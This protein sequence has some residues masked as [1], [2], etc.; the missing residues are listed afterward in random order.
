MTRRISIVVI[1]LVFAICGTVGASEPTTAP[2][3][4]DA[5]RRLVAAVE[6]MTKNDPRGAAAEVRAATKLVDADAAEERL[7]SIAE[8]LERGDLSDKGELARALAEVGLDV[9]AHHNEQTKWLLEQD[10]YLDAARELDAAACWLKHSAGA[11][12]PQ[13][14]AE[15]VTFVG[16]AQRAAADLR[17]TAKDDKE[18]AEND[19][20]GAQP[21]GGTDVKGATDAEARNAAQHALK[22]TEEL[23]EQVRTLKEQI[24]RADRAR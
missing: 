20:H 8:R 2:A 3:G 14:P 24:T 10:K 21:A 16:N 19:G 11:L 7:G 17:E 22:I 5:R 13:P 15:L 23:A 18:L 9:A 1:L 4:D 6:M 12:H